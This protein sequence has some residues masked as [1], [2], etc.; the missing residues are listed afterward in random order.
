MFYYK[1][2]CPIVA[3]GTKFFTSFWDFNLTAP[4]LSD[5]S[6]FNYETCGILWMVKKYP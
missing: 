4:F 5:F 2:G 3:F 1:S 6:T